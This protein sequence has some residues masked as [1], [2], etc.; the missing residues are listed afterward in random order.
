MLAA[1]RRLEAGPSRPT[2]SGLGWIGVIT[3]GPEDLAEQAK[4]ILRDDLG[5]R[6]GPAARSWP[7][8]GC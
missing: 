8:A 4:R 3:D 6:H 5:Q 2:T 1:A 7:T